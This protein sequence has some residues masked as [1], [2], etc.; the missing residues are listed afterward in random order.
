MIYF[1]HQKQKEAFERVNKNQKEAKM[2]AIIKAQEFVCQAHREYLEKCG[3]SIE[4]CGVEAC[5]GYLYTQGIID[6]DYEK[7]VE[8]ENES[9][10]QTYQTDSCEIEE[11]FQEE[12]LPRKYDS[13]GVSKRAYEKWSRFVKDAKERFGGHEEVEALV[14]VSSR[15]DS[16]IHDVI[17]YRE[18]V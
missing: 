10:S 12:V 7:I 1:Q 9:F 13:D 2:E 14:F 8:L 16:G 11:F 5:F 6:E 15:D 3:W 18:A 4:E 17:F